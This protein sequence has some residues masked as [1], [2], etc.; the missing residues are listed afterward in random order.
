MSD[1]YS[2]NH[3][4][5]KAYQFHKKLLALNDSTHNQ[6]LISKTTQ[7]KVLFDVEKMENEKKMLLEDNKIKAANYLQ[8]Q[9]MFRYLIL[10]SSLIFVL[11]I[12]STLMYIQKNKVTKYLV[13]KNIELS[14]SRENT[15]NGKLR[16]DSKKQENKYANSSL[17]ED[18]KVQLNDSINKRFFK[19]EAFLN[20]DFTLNSF[21]KELKTNRNYISQVI[22]ERYDVNF[23]TFI[24]EQRI[25]KAIQLLSDK[26]N[27]IYTIDSIANMVGFNSKSSF[28]TAFKK[29]TGITPSSFIKSIK[30]SSTTLS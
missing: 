6:A 4:Y 18:K 9:K 2:A 28:N 12:I 16:I 14:Y 10:A 7:L 26:K 25:K 29:Q 30:E 5:Q 3:Q 15:P 8:Q 13:K 20:P 27:H 1:Y 17:S 22:N 19:E 24:N 21:A 23:S 11:F